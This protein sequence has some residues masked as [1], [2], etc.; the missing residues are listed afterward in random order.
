MILS[1]RE[2]LELIDDGMIA[3]AE[4]KLVGRSEGRM[5][6]GV[7]SFGYDLRLGNEFAVY[8][9]SDEPLDPRDVQAEDLEWSKVD[10]VFVLPPKGFV[11][12]VTMETMKLPRNVTG[13]VHDK[14]SYARCGL[15]AQNTVLESGWSG[16]VT[17]EVT[18]HLDR[19][20]KLLVGH[21]IV[22]VLFFRGELCHTS[23]ADRNGSYMGQRGVTIP[24]TARA[25]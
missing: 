15:S 12:A 16:Q 10:D 17:L 5:S 18:N 21:G 20:V 14:S 13:L 1:D 23:Y 24:T 4:R 22:Q 3:P 19:P 11:L 7:S 25:R 8:R 9:P 6:F 2:I